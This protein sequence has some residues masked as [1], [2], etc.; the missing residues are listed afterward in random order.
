M[1]D[2]LIEQITDAIA[3][4]VTGL[5]TTGARVFRDRVR[6]LDD[7]E[8]PCL[9]IQDSDESPPLLVATGLSSAVGRQL[10]RTV[11]IDIVAYVQ[12]DAPSATL[13]LI[14]KEVEIALSADNTLGGITLDLLYGGRQRTTSGEGKNVVGGNVMNYTATYRCGEKQ[15]D[16]AG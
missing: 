1:A 3:T 7:G 9:V 15:P 4:K 13:N 6:A 16:V 10:H 5:A 14:Q 2:H 8:F 11:L 12:E